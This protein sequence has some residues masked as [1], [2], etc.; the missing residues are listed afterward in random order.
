MSDK[1]TIHSEFL[2]IRRRLLT[3][4]RTP[5]RVTFSTLGHMEMLREAD[6]N[7]SL[8][9]RDTATYSGL[10]YTVSTKQISRVALHAEPEQE[11]PVRVSVRGPMVGTSVIEVFASQLSAAQLCDICMKWLEGDCQKWGDFEKRLHAL[12]L[13]HGTFE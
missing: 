2:E 9:N 7:G 8:V 6:R 1:Q 3:S 10:P 13:E 4:G 11:T 5:L 12:I